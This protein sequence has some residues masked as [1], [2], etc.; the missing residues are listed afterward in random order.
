MKRLAPLL[1]LLAMLLTRT[2]CAQE[3][4]VGPGQIILEMTLEAQMGSRSI[5]ASPKVAV[6]PGSPATVRI[7][8]DEPGKEFAW[9]I[10]TTPTLVEGGIRI[11]LEF[12]LVAADRKASRVFDFTAADGET[13]KLE[14]RS[15][16]SQEVIRL[17]VLPRVVR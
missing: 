9:T 3:V 12:E 6:K 14:D 15:Q 1:L 17:L 7:A 10:T 13:T 11:H 2:A 4:A 16:D 5:A 8:S